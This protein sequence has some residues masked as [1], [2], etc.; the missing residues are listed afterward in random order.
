M[1]NFVN[2][3]NAGT[4]LVMLSIYCHGWRRN[5]LKDPQITL[6]K[7]MQIVNVIKKICKTAKNPVKFYE[8]PISL[9]I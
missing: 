6:L 3:N 9:L 7:K 2:I 4:F 5:D 1:K 8:N